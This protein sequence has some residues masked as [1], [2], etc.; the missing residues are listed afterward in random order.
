MDRADRLELI[1]LRVSVAQACDVAGVET[2][3]L[4]VIG[5]SFHELVWM[6]NH[7][8]HGWNT[9]ISALAEKVKI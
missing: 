9:L 5:K 7:K 2:R 1:M 6:A 8:D 3:N 4:R